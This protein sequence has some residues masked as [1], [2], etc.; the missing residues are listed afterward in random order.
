M[1]VILVYAQVSC[2]IAAIAY[3]LIADPAFDLIAE[4]DNLVNRNLFWSR[5]GVFV[6]LWLTAPY[7]ALVL[8][9]GKKQRLKF[10]LA[11]ADGLRDSKA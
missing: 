8:L 2:V 11:L 9:L 5:L 4:E 7:M 3:Q 6:G 10:T 1:E